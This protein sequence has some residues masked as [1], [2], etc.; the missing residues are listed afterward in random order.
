MR[1]I[2]FFGLVVALGLVASV[3]NGEDVKSGPDKK[4]GGAFNVKAV[5][6]EK[7]G[8]TLCYVCKFGGE[9]RPASVLVFTQK[10]DDNLVEVV[11]AI[12]GVQKTNDKLGTVVIGVSGVQE[13]DFEKIQTTHKLTTPLTVAED[14]DGPK[15]Y[16]LNK[17]AVVTVVVYKKGGEVSKNFAFK[18]TK[19]AAAKAKD[20]AA[21]ASEAL[22]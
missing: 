10:A 3:A 8:K 6:G 14:K 13:A 4:I 15:A 2:R 18:T 20:I 9:Q 12:D 5:T 22:K 17:D 1:A 11:K 7:A 19:D 21:A 16:T